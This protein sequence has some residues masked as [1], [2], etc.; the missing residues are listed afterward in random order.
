MGTVV[1]E[2]ILAPQGGHVHIAAS[3]F[4]APACPP[5]PPLQTKFRQDQHCTIVCR[6]ESL[7]KAQ[8]K[9]FKSKIADEYRVN[10]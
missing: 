3:R 10:M 1:V 6:L 5:A 7:S 4:K 8:E 2:G 9:A